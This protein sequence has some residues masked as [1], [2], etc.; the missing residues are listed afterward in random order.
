MNT[1]KITSLELIKM[2]VNEYRGIA[3]VLS[4]GALRLLGISY[5]KY[6]RVY[7]DLLTRDIVI[8]YE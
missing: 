3:V 6:V 1:K 4:V 5:K 2:G 7:Q 8:E